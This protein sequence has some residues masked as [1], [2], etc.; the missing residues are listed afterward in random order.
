MA[1]FYDKCNFRHSAIGGTL[2]YVPPNS[3]K[4]TNSL[5]QIILFFARNHNYAVIWSNHDTHTNM[6]AIP[7]V[8]VHTNTHTSKVHACDLML[9]Q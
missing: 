6:Q 1:R 3:Q 7:D 4:Y 8:D 5:C 9:N 2:K